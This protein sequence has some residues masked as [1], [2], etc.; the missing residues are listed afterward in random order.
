MKTYQGWLIHKQY[1]KIEV[2]ASSLEEAREMIWEAEFN[3][4]KPDD[5]GAE[6][7]DVEEITV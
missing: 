3:W 7:Y 6:I 1:F 5:M 4:S 2:E